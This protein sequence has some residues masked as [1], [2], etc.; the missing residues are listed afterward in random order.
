MILFLILC[1][2]S[3]YC[4]RFLDSADAPLGMTE[5]TPLTL[6]KRVTAG[7]M[8][9]VISTLQKYGFYP[10]FFTIF[11]SWT[12]INTNSHK[13]GSENILADRRHYCFSRICGD[14]GNPASAGTD[15]YYRQGGQQGFRE[16]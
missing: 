9:Y 10:I 5:E 4:I 1:L 13:K 14:T 2:T 15:L 8:F 6:T 16:I 7:G 3:L 12:N 11:A